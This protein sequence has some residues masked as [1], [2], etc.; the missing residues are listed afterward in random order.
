MSPEFQPTRLNKFVFGVLMPASL[1][2]FMLRAVSEIAR[3]RRYIENY[4]VA[5]HGHG[6]EAQIISSSV[7]SNPV[8]GV[9]SFRYNGSSGPTDCLVRLVLGKQSNYLNYKA[10]KS[11]VV[12]PSNGCQGPVVSTD[13]SFPVFDIIILIIPILFALY[14]LVAMIKFFRQNSVLGS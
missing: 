14:N 6:I 12:V 2:V 3:I 7:D 5:K 11:I 4:Y 13:A 10:G 9:V 1:V 8:I